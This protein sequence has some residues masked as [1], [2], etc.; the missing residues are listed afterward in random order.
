MNTLRQS[1][2][3][4][5]LLLAFASCQKDEPKDTTPPTATI[6]GFTLNSTPTAPST[7]PIPIAKTEVTLRVN[8][9]FADNAALKSYTVTMSPTFS[10][11]NTADNNWNFVISSDTLTGKSRDIP[12]LSLRATGT[13]M[14]LNQFRLR[15][16]TKDAAGNASAPADQI[17][18]VTN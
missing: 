3:A 5:V 10:P 9:R 8:L 14:T 11:T 4:V 1:L 2:A 15:V 12:S 17:F 16:E 6:L 7:G 13:D 18:Q